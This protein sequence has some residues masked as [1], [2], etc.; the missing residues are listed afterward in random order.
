MHK[1]KGE[2][3]VYCVNCG[4]ELQKEWN[5]CPSC[6]IAKQQTSNPV[7][8]SASDSEKIGGTLLTKSLTT[9][10]YREALFEN[11]SKGLTVLLSLLIPGAVHLYTE[12]I[13]AGIIYFFLNLILFSVFFASDGAFMCSIMWFIFYIV[14]V[15]DSVSPV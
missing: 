13:F 12:R 8:R 10:Q 4:T 14:C 7:G 11:K 15:T 1:N 3:M 6:G 2:I 5:I 9:L